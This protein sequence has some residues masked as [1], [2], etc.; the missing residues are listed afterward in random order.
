[1]TPP[2]QGTFASAV[3]RLSSDTSYSAYVAMSNVFQGLTSEATGLEPLKIAISRNFTIDAIAPVLE[4]ELALAGFHL[5]LHVG[6]YD[7]ISQELLD[8]HSRFYAFE[9]DLIFIAQWLEVLAPQLSNRF[10]SLSAASVTSEIDRILSEMRDRLSALRRHSAAPVVLNNFVLPTH[11]TLGIL[12]GQSESYQTASILRLNNG[13]L[14][15]AR[16]FRDI[17]I[18]DLMSLTARIGYAEALDERYWHIGRAPLS[19][20]ALITLAREYVKFVRALRGQTRKCLVLDCDNTL[21]GGVVGEDGIEGI[22]LGHTYPGS[23]YTAFQSEILN[24][25]DRGVILALCSK[26]NEEDVREVFRNHPDMVLREEHFAA[27]QINWG[28]KVTNLRKIARQLNV[29]LDALVLADDSRFECDLVRDTLPQVATIYLG[30]EPSAFARLLNVGAYFDS[31]TLSVE[32]R[33][34]TQLYH[35]EAQREELRESATSLHSYLTQLQIVASIGT[36]DNVSIPRIAQLTQ[37]T[38][39][40]NLTTRRYNEG[41]IR[42]LCADPTVDVFCMK[43]RDRVSDLGLVGVA[44]IRYE[45]KKAHIDT[46]LLSCR[47]L[48]RGAEDCLLFHCLRSAAARGAEQVLGR[49]TRTSKNEQVADFFSRCNFANLS[50]GPEGGTWMFQTSRDSFIAPDWIQVETVGLKETYAG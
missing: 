47:A 31:L 37:K 13:L 7:A 8:P 45:A 2:G 24:L 26:N 39:Q 28:D 19:R 10:L 18:L 12:D 17:Y 35:S 16:E 23:C 34:R 15:C 50:L 41:E 40:F 42:A 3:A 14:R 6:E 36:G 9:P 25:K 32:D 43:L 46:F 4:G 27:W 30:K 5:K 11:P 20:T 33:I 29:D 38:N 49:Y 21:W 48:S 22:K 44:I 1:M